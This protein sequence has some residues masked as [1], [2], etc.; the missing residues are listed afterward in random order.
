VVLHAE[1]RA[2]APIKVR[3]ASAAAMI[4]DILSNPATDGGGLARPPESVS[5]TGLGAGHIGK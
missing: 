2:A 1:S 5:D 3:T 4:R